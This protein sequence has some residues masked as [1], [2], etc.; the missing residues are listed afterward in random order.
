MGRKETRAAS[1][2]ALVVKNHLP[3]QET[4]ER[5][6]IPGWGRSPRGGQDN[7][8]QCSY[9]ENPRG[10]RSLVGYSPW[11]RKE[12][13]TTERLKT[14]KEAGSKESGSWVMK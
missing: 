1:Q 5:G 10:Q 11:S 4:E 12:S 13:D 6:L 9:L 3:M 2:V 14:G 8:L 7:T